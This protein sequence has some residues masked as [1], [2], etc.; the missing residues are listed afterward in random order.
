MG[1]LR[2]R[3]QSPEVRRMKRE[4]AR[5]IQARWTV[6]SLAQTA[7]IQGYRALY[8]RVGAG[9]E[10]LTPSCEVLIQT[11]LRSGHLPTINTLV[12]LYNG[13][14]ASR[15]VTIG[16]HDA[17]RIVG[18]IRVGITTGR[19]RFV[20]LGNSDPVP[21]RPGEYAYFDDSDVLCRLDVRQ[22]DKTKLLLETTD[23][24]LV[25]NNNAA[26]SEGALV[27]ACEEVCRL[28]RDLLGAE[29]EVVSV[30]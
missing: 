23:A 4:V 6:E 11:V 19:E 7:P 28:A 13:V 26:V 21:V 3:K 8:E 16:A 29:A 12:D 22:C 20:P 5:E 14:S 1:G 2:L 17:S 25:A 18:D 30:T 15:L 9:A 27:G 10:N 24:I